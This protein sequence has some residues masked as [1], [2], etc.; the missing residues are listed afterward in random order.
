MDEIKKAIDAVNAGQAAGPDGIPIDIYKK[1]KSKFI[2]PVMEMF[3]ASYKNGS[4][5]P[6]PREAMITIFKT[7]QTS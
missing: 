7:E 1:F 3:Q 2:I 4:L 6:S 5:P